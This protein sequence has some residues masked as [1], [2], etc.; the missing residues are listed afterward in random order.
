MLALLATAHAHT[1]GG[2]GARAGEGAVSFQRR[3]SGLQLI[4]LLLELEHP[5]FED[6]DG[7]GDGDAAPPVGDRLCDALLDQARGGRETA[8]A[9]AR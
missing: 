9:R 8:R 6:V 1:G 7:G 5:L 2:H 4:G 3:L